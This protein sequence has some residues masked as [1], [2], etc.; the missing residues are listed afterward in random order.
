MTEDVAAQL[1]ALMAGAAYIGILKLFST[2]WSRRERLRPDPSLEREVTAAVGTVPAGL[3]VSV[4]ARSGSGGRC[5]RIV[6]SGVC[7]ALGLGPETRDDIDLGDEALDRLFAFRGPRSLLC[8][9]MD[10]DTR[11]RLMDLARTPEVRSGSLTVVDGA[12]SLDVRRPLYRP[13]RSRI[14]SVAKQAL[15]LAQ[16]LQ[17]PADIPAR[18]AENALDNAQRGVRLANLRALLREHAGEW[19]TRD[20]LRRA[21]AH[22]DPELRLMAAQAMGDEGR[23]V[24]IDLARDT[25]TEDEACAGAIEALGTLP[26]ADLETVL[27]ASLGPAGGRAAR[28]FTARACAD[29]LAKCGAAALPLLADVVRARSEAVALAGVRALRRIGTAEAVLPLT[30]AAATGEGAVREAARAA[31]EDIQLGLRGTPGAVSLSEGEAGVLSLADDPSGRLS[32]PPARE[33]NR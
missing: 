29:L 26:L 15:A 2:D 31:L 3:S 18:L 13:T 9:M 19:V 7:P 1:I 6:V 28:P 27:A 5:A 24:V 8:A 23:S 30:E 33:R 10:G 20:A 16:R 4:R 12:L 17:A 14:V 21:T 22:P 11:S 32:V 25:S